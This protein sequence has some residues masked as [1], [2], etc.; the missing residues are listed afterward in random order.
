MKSTKPLFIDTLSNEAIFVQAQPLD[1]QSLEQ[2]K[3]WKTVYPD[4]DSMSVA[5]AECYTGESYDDIDLARIE[6]D[7]HFSENSHYFTPMHSYYYPIPYLANSRDA[8]A[9]LLS[10]ISDCI[11]VELEDE[12]YALALKSTGSDYSW[13]IAK[14]YI[15]L[16][17]LPPFTFCN[18]PELAEDTDKEVIKACMMSCMEVCNQSLNVY[19]SLA[20]L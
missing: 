8:Q 18:L 1:W 9:I 7:E 10:N 13:E 4:I 11:L 16:G 6:L 19:N 20:E 15:L 2:S 14:A 3:R 17:Y 5:D 12:Q